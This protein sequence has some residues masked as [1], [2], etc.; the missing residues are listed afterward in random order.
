[1]QTDTMNSPEQTEISP[2]RFPNLLK[3]KK[4]TFSNR[5]RTKNTSPRT[6]VDTPRT[7]VDITLKQPK[8]K[9]LCTHTSTP[10]DLTATFDSIATD[11]ENTALFQGVVTLRLVIAYYYRCVLRAPPECEWE[12]PGGAISMVRCTF[13]LRWKTTRFVRKVFKDVNKCV[14]MNC[15][16][17][18]KPVYKI[19]TGAP[20]LIQKGSVYEQLIAH[21]MEGGFGTRFVTLMVNT[22]RVD[23]EKSIFGRSAVTD[24]AKRMRPIVTKIQKRNQ[25]NK[26]H[27]GWQNARFYQTLQMVIMLREISTPNI[28]I[29]LKL[30]SIQQLP[31]AFNPSMLPK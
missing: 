29:K 12:G 6:V 30:E 15:T 8:R 5:R 19:P 20:H 10:Q 27:Q 13:E 11:E 3:S 22:Q 23:E 14:E 26:N 2:P 9:R 7:I 24:A 31:P 18:G 4:K 16:Y 28:L 17:N 1:M 21:Y 25:G